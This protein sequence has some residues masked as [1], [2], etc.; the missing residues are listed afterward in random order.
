LSWSEFRKSIVGVLRATSSSRWRWKKWMSHGSGTGATTGQSRNKLL[1]LCHDLA[2]RA[3]VIRGQGSVDGND[4]GD[5]AIRQRPA[6]VDNWLGLG[7]AREGPLCIERVSG[8]RPMVQSNG[9]IDKRQVSVE[10]WS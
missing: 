8:E 9:T 3:E 5:L 6:L 7:S 1:N 4:E 10:V 2:N